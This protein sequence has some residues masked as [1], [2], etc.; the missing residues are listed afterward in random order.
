MSWRNIRISKTAPAS[1]DTICSLKLPS[2]H[3]TKKT[4]PE[5]NCSMV[6]LDWKCLRRNR[7][8]RVK[9]LPGKF[10]WGDCAPCW[11]NKEQKLNLTPK[12]ALAVSRHIL[13]SPKS[14][15]KKSQ[16]SVQVYAVVIRA[17]LKG[18][19]SWR[20]R[21]WLWRLTNRVSKLRSVPDLWILHL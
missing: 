8:R 2:L 19:I 1:H 12:A 15:C 3:K 14:K 17:G 6:Q 5:R 16:K 4:R 7:S 11:W 20:L 13:N 10:N 9:W 18:H 21:V